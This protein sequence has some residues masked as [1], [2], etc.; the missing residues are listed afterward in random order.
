MVEF[1]SLCFFC[2]YLFLFLLPQISFSQFLHLPF[3]LFL[4]SPSILVLSL[5]ELF[6]Q[7]PPLVGAH[8]G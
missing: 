4:L 7:V 8:S 3:F 6:K 5:L 1:R 2:L